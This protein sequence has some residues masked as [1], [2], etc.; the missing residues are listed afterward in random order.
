MYAIRA[1]Q[2]YLNTNLVCNVSLYSSL[3][4]GS[5]SPSPVCGFVGLLFCKVDPV[6]VAPSCVLFCLSCLESVDSRLESVFS[7][8]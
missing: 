7:K 6:P 3:V 1:L 2:I 4:T 8:S 5:I